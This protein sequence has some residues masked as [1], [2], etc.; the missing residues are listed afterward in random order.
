MN[1]AM[2]VRVGL[3][4]LDAS[5]KWLAD[6]LGVTPQHITNVCKGNTQLGV[7]S[8]ADVSAV[9]GVPVSEFIKWGE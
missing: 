7:N 9:F 4:R 8:I 5:K 3:A 2:S 1:T 6:E